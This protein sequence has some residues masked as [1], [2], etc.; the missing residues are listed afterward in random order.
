M[1]IS[2]SAI[3]N[4]IYRL[5]REYDWPK[6]DRSPCCNSC[7]VWGHGYFKRFQAPIATIR[8][9]IAS[10]INDGKWIAGICRNRHIPAFQLTPHRAIKQHRSV[11]QVNFYNFFHSNVQQVVYGDGGQPM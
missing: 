11:G 8:A 6:P 5:G 1:I 4:E 2:F 9:S 3:L 10:K 7:R